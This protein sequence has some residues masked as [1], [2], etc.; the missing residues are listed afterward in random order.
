MIFTGRR[1][2][3]GL[4]T[5]LAIAVAVLVLLFHQGR[6]LRSDLAAAQQRLEDWPQLS[7]YQTDNWERLTTFNFPEAVFIGD[8]I[9]QLWDRTAADGFFPDRFYANRGI[10]GQTTP[11]ILLRFRQDVIN[12]RPQ[13]VVIAAGTNDLA[14][15][16]GPVTLAQIQDNLA[17]MA[18]LA[19]VHGIQVVL[20]SLLPIHDQAVDGN[21]QPI[22]RTQ[23]RSQA[24]L[25]QL[26]HWLRTYATT[27]GHLYLDYATA[28]QDDQ[29]W[30]RVDYSD[31]G[32]HPNAAGYGVMAP[33]AI[34]AVEQAL[35]TAPARAPANRE[36]P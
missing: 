26:N 27:H 22:R 30:L 21:G 12:L 19:A 11:Q 17:S 33:L 6:S 5:L 23:E 2:V 15:L 18:E 16:T 4:A 36:L 3:A 25:Q 24:D 31:D 10:S 34:A 14:G 1:T 8:S 35:A 29:G 20:A 32:L 13:V 9:T 28:L 7:R